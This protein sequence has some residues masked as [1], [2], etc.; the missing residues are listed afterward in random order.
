MNQWP[1]HQIIKVHSTIIKGSWMQNPDG[2]V[3]KLLVSSFLSYYK[4]PINKKL[5]KHPKKIK[6]LAKEIRKRKTIKQTWVKARIAIMLSTQARPTFTPTSSR[7]KLQDFSFS[8]NICLPISHLFPLLH[9]QK[10]LYAVYLI[11]SSTFSLNK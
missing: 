6:F 8:P 1:T 4:P 2:T 3:L 7:G 10:W 11:I 9:K 5:T